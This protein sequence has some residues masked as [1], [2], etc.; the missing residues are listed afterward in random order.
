M[1]PRVNRDQVEAEARAKILWGEPPEQALSFLRVNG[2]SAEEAS[3]LVESFMAERRATV[4]GIG[5]KKIGIGIFLVAVPAVT[6]VIFLFMRVIFIKLS[7]ITSAVGVWGLWK[8]I[9]GAMKMLNPG[10]D[11]GDLADEDV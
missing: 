9:D 4:R 11:T 5:L 8:I 3:E 2:L 7:I 10:M 6:W 1:S